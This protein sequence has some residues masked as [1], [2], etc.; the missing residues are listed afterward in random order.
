MVR[1]GTAR[2][3]S[4]DEEAV[5]VNVSGLLLEILP[6]GHDDDPRVPVLITAAVEIR[7]FA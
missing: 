6:P 3:V 7:P 1:R 5:C 2:G 4:W